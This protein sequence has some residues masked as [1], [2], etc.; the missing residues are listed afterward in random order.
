MAKNLRN[1]RRILDARDDP[2]L[3]AARA[4]RH[5]PGSSCATR[6]PSPVFSRRSGQVS[7]SMAKTRLRRCIQFIGALGLSL[8]IRVVVRRGTMRMRCLK[9]GANTP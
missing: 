3:A 2:E 5:T 9:L 6:K 1:Q 4:D 7:M 8:S